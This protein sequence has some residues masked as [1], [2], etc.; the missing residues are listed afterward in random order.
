MEAGVDCSNLALVRNGGDMD[1][2][3]LSSG[4]REPWQ[5]SLGIVWRPG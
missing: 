4:N 5:G 1:E 3:P 2:P